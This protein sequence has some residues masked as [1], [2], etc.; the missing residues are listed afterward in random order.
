MGFLT[1]IALL[2]SDLAAGHEPAADSAWRGS[3]PGP[4][5]GAGGSDA[6]YPAELACHGLNRG[7]GGRQSSCWMKLPATPVRRDFT[8]P[9]SVL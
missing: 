7:R 3:S 9:G 6:R 4:R 8:V 2:L 1:W 5:S